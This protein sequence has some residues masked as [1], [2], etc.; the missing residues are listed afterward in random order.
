MLGYVP[1]TDSFF[2]HPGAE[3]TDWKLGHRDALHHCCWRPSSNELVLVFEATTRS[4]VRKL[5]RISWCN[6]LIKWPLHLQQ[7]RRLR[8]S[9]TNVVFTQSRHRMSFLRRRCCVNVVPSQQI[10]KKEKVTR[11][12]KEFHFCSFWSREFS[13]TSSKCCFTRKRRIVGDKHTPFIL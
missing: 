10:L 12:L 13:V 5:L 11:C 8:H 3:S 9:S 6:K 1:Y 7:H 2:Q 4:P